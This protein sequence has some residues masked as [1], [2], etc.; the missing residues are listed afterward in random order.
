MA[1]DVFTWSAKTPASLTTRLRE[2]AYSP[3]LDRWCLVGDGGKVVTSDDSGDT[4]TERTSG[5]TGTYFLSVAWGGS[6]MF[7]AVGGDNTSTTGPAIYTSPDGITWTSRTLSKNARYLWNIVWTGTNWVTSGRGGAMATSPDGITWTQR[8]IDNVDQVSDDGDNFYRMDYDG[9]SRLVVTASVSSEIRL[10]HSDDDGVTW[11][12]CAPISIAGITSMKWTG[13]CWFAFGAYVFRRKLYGDAVNEMMSSSDGY[14]WV[15][16]EFPYSDLC[17]PKFYAMTSDRAGEAVLVGNMNPAWSFTGTSGNLVWKEL[18]DVPNRHTYWYRGAGYGNGNY[19]MCGDAN[20]YIPVNGGNRPLV[21]KGWWTNSNAATAPNPADQPYATSG[22]NITSINSQLSWTGTGSGTHA[23]YLGKNP[24]VMPLEGNVGISTSYDPGTL[25]Y[26]TGY[27]WRVDIIDGATATGE[28]W[29]FVTE[30]QHTLPDD[31]L[32]VFTDTSRLTSSQ[33]EY[34]PATL[35]CDIDHTEL[36]H[37]HRYLITRSGKWYTYTGTG[38]ERVYLGNKTETVQNNVNPGPWAYPNHNFELYQNAKG[39]FRGSNYKMVGRQ[40]ASIVTP[41]GGDDIIWQSYKSTGTVNRYACYFMVIDLDSPGLIEGVDW[42]SISESKYT[43]PPF[44]VWED[45][46]NGAITFTPDG[47]SDY[48]ILGSMNWYCSS[49][50]TSYPYRARINDTVEGVLATGGVNTSYAAADY[51]HNFVMQWVLESPTATERTVGM[52]YWQKDPGVSYQPYRLYGSD[53]F[54]LRIS[55]FESTKVLQKNAPITNMENYMPP[56]GTNQKDA[57]QGVVKYKPDSNVDPLF[58]FCSEIDPSNYSST[59]VC[60]G[61]RYGTGS[62]YPYTTEN[63][64]YGGTIG[65][66]DYL[67]MNAYD[68]EHRTTQYGVRQLT[69]LSSDPAPVYVMAAAQ[70]TSDILGR[71]SLAVIGTK[72]TD[73]PAVYN[74]VP[75]DG[76]RTIEKTAPISFD[77]LAPAGVDR[78][79]LN[80]D[81]LPC[82]GWAENPTGV[83][84]LSRVAHNGSLWVGCGSAG[85]IVTSTDGYSWTER[86]S[87]TAE[88]LGG[89]AYGAGVWVVCG[90]HETFLS[91]T[92]GITWIDRS[93]GAATDH[94]YEVVYG[95]GVFVAVG[96]SGAIYSSSDGTTW[97]ARGSETQYMYSV[98]YDSINGLFCAVGWNGFIVT[99][100]NGTTWTTRSSGTYEALYG[101]GHDQQGR[102]HATVLYTQHLLTS[103]NGINW[104]LVETYLPTDTDMRGIRYGGGRWVGTGING[105]SITS[106]DGGSTWYQTKVLS[107]GT[108]NCPTYASGIGWLITVSNGNVLTSPNGGIAS[109]AIRRC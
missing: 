84:H 76:A 55:K 30:P 39:V 24:D 36:I 77:V 38:V 69:G 59:G 70:N 40:G 75:G 57:Q 14:T 4:W 21:A 7:I 80:V 28:Q 45:I 44:D 96:A 12:D 3:T 94:M 104:S 109:H 91:S 58:I 11:T 98:A 67:N 2:A 63:Y 78:D 92:D 100:P 62:T 17:P 61:V 18:P 82:E 27:W 6:G 71:Y 48:L 15:T 99:S 66:A 83:N 41:I 60:I 43:V 101:V 93:P 37:G 1:F 88:S 89:V 16:E 105:M 73:V 106:V 8:N 13:S 31:E 108:L 22:I 95:G 54:I 68:V 87:G 86:T 81:I 49:T 52:Q 64:P 19:I 42:W 53:L 33:T 25:E 20:Y 23:V 103:T 72:Y 107:A 51:Q 97:T 26:N 10:F 90:G 46:P 34:Y 65:S 29:H 47:Y 85:K 50:S 5:F 102:W 9:T 32:T 56:Y 74:F 35:I 79:T